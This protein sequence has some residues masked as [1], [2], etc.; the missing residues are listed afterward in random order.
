MR[1]V[2]RVPVL[3]W[4]HCRMHWTITERP[5]CVSRC[6]ASSL[7]SHENAPEW[8]RW[9]ESILAMRIPLYPIQSE[10]AQIESINRRCGSISV[11]SHE[12]TN[13]L[14]VGNTIT[15]YSGLEAS[16]ANPMAGTKTAAS[17]SVVRIS[18]CKFGH[19]CCHRS[20]WSECKCGM[21]DCQ[22]LLI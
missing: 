13:Y 21:F 18:R 19:T 14:N 11:W 5:L 4:S 22:H 15:S 10:S 9:P 6:V 3:E 7:I 2:V 16:A 17:T 8:W 20:F 1:R 12:C